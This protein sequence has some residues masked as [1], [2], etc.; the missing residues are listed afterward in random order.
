M[1]F[2]VW[3]CY[4]RIYSK[5][6]CVWHTVYWAAD[7]EKEEKNCFKG[8]LKGDGFVFV[9]QHAYNFWGDVKHIAP[10]LL[11]VCNVRS[12]EK[13]TWISKGIDSFYLILTVLL[14]V[15][16]KPW[17]YFGSCK[18]VTLRKKESSKIKKRRNSLTHKRISFVWREKFQE[19]WN[20]AWVVIV[21][22]KILSNWH[23][24][25]FLLSDC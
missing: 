16:Y 2:R 25:Q 19:K 12:C 24:L 22:W 15:A 7:F 1:L 23:I 10:T 5:L 3:R 17:K 9:S 11:W 21:R 8:F 13:L 6:Q 4:I 20:C 14:I 18:K